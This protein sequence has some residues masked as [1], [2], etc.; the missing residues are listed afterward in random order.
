LFL[1]DAGAA[2][3][4]SSVAVIGLFSGAGGLEVGAAA[5]GAEVRLAVEIDAQA[6]A[7]LQ[8]NSTH[9]PAAVL[10]A[11]LTTLDGAALRR[12]ANLDARTPCLVIGG[13]PCQP[14]SKAA[15][16]TDPGHDSAYRRARSRGEALPAKPTPITEATPDARRDLVAEFMRLV[17]EIDAQGFLFENVPSILHP[18]SRKILDT[19]IERAENNGYSTRRLQVN[20][21]DFGVAQARQRVVVLGLK[22]GTPGMPVP[23]HTGHHVGTGTVLEPF[24]GPEFHEPEEVVTG[25]YAEHLREIPPGMNYKAL[26]AWAGHPN[27]SFEA[28]TRFWSFLLKL[29]PKLPSWTIPANPGPWVGPFHWESRRLRTPELAALQGFPRGYQFVGNR[30]ARVR[31]IGNAV[32]ALLAQR[33][34]EPLV[35][36]LTGRRAAS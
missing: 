6:C 28:E 5:A 4:A 16:W 1:F 19:L 22:G 26:T 10:Q 34:M 31:Q 3:M 7:T 25:R 24:A 17:L 21:A 23:T 13:P 32:P 9:Q 14:F 12:H 29:D 20:A 36:A 30:R 18:R 15:Y 8:A 11:D 33:M 2:T 35:E 27:P